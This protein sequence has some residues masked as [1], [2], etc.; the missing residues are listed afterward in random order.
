VSI[1][2]VGCVIFLANQDRS[3][4]GSYYFNQL[5]ALQVLVG[6][7]NAAQNTTTTYFSTLYMNQVDQNGEQV[8]TNLSHLV[9]IHALSSL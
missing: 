1:I 4:H 7:T 2:T 3:N 5:A 6:D 9:C 8:G